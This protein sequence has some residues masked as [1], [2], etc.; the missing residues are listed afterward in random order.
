MRA[1]FMTAA[2]IMGDC[3]RACYSRHNPFSFWRMD[4]AVA[5]ADSRSENVGVKPIVVPE[6]KFPVWAAPVGPDLTVTFDVSATPLPATLPLF[7]GGLGFVG[8]LTRRK[9]RNAQA[10]AAA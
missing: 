2:L 6:L 5:S 3:C 10:L 8:F 1:E 9:K 4:L 7:A